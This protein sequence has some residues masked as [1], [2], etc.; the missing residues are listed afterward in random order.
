M[1]GNRK[2][3]KNNIRNVYKCAYG[4]VIFNVEGCHFIIQTFGK[5]GI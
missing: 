4:V 5:R 2:L 3:A 1:N